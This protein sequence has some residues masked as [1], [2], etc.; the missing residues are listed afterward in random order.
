M[1]VDTINCST[2][3]E[4]LVETNIKATLAGIS[5]LFSLLDNDHEHS[6]HVESVGTNVGSRAHYLGAKFEDMVLV[7]QVLVTV[8]SFLLSVLNFT[9]YALHLLALHS[10]YANFKNSLRSTGIPSRNEF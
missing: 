3:T 7:L 1:T 8:L 4:Q 10:S 2:W 6:R 9:I 5:V